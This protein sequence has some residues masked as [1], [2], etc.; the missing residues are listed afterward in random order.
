MLNRYLNQGLLIATVTLGLASAPVL[1]HAAE[2]VSVVAD[3]GAWKEL[4]AETVIDAPPAAVWSALTNYANMKNVLPGYQRSTVLQA[5]GA[6]SIVDV[7]LKPG[8]MA[9]LLKY[10]VRITENKSAQSIAIQRI[11]G[12]LKHVKATYRIQPLEN[13]T[14]SRLSYR[15]EVDLGNDVPK[16]GATQI[17]KGNTQKGMAAMR[18]HCANT[19]RRSLT[20]SAK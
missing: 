12:D 20:A 14:K 18:Q 6:N 19:H 7:A 16:M 15:L 5:S 8:A 2:Q 3:K 13:G 4:Q 17:L 11:S 10:Q 1:A 9:P